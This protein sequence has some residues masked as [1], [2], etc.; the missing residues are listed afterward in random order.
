[1]GI[2]AS[3][4]CDGTVIV[5]SI[6]ASVLVAD[7]LQFSPAFIPVGFFLLRVVTNG[8]IIEW[9]YCLALKLAISGMQ[10]NH[11]KLICKFRLL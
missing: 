10:D 7:S 11:I 1:M 8:L 4:Y 9:T 5:I 6:A 3:R 2:L